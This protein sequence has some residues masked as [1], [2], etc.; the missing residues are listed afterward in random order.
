MA[1]DNNR[2][3]G[4]VD[5]TH[6][7]LRPSVGLAETFGSIGPSHSRVAA[8]DQVLQLHRDQLR[9]MPQHEGRA[10]ANESEMPAVR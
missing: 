5:G 1:A 6:A 4:R 2:P 9:S 7:R 3:M 8:V 10:A